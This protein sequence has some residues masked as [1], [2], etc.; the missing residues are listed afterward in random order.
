[1]P[2]LDRPGALETPIYALSDGTIISDIPKIPPQASWKWDDIQAWMDGHFKVRPIKTIIDDLNAIIRSQ[3]WLP[4]DNDYLVLALIIVITYVQTIFEAVPLVLATGAKGSG[5]SQ[6][7]M[8]MAKVAANGIVVGD[9][10]AATI[11]RTLDETRGFL[12]LDDVEK[13]CSKV[14]SSNL[15]MDNFL[16]ILKVSYKKATATKTVTDT[17]TMTVKTLNFY[18]V[19]FM[20]NTQG[21][22]EVLGSRTII[23][24]TVKAS[25]ANFTVK[26]LDEGL[27]DRLKPELHA[28]SMD[29]AETLHQCYVKY[30]LTDRSLEITAPLRA[31]IDMAEMPEWHAVID[32]L[33]ERMNMDQKSINSPEEVVKEAAFQL[34]KRGYD[35]FCCEQVI[36]EM[37]TL[38]PDN[39]MKSHTSEIPEWH[40]V[41]WVRH[42]LKNLQ[43]IS[44][45]DSSRSRPYGKAPMARFYKIEERLFEEM[46]V[47]NAEQFRAIKRTKDGAR[48]C[49][50][51]TCRE[52]PYENAHCYIQETTNKNSYIVRD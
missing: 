51:T 25:T 40:Q 23:I 17:K 50:S 3:I 37:K 26:D 22:E 19:K 6:L 44:S 14:N 18:G 21:I 8:L 52:C 33:I 1:M 48:F 32:D 7:G 10:S 16:Q 29:N 41:E 46:K 34:A 4:N 49:K 15:Q 13:I 27:I 45:T 20:T 31:I 2:I 12:M 36:L 30:P 39:F 43:Y 42:Q 28:W 38:V 5:K 35:S 9:T 24:H 47:T 11:A